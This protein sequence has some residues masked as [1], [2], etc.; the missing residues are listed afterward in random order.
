MQKPAY[1]P[2]WL[3]LLTLAYPSFAGTALAS[4]GTDSSGNAIPSGVLTQCAQPDFAHYLDAILHDDMKY[5]ILAAVIMIVFS[6][7]QYMLAGAGSPD[8]QKKAKQ[9]I[10]GILSGVAMLMLV[11]LLA[12]LLIHIPT[13]T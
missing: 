12:S 7:L 2:I 11:N 4:C 8:M 10:L 13:T 9:R 3:F 6:G 5:I 1:R